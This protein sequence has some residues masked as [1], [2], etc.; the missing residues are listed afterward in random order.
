MDHDVLRGG[1]FCLYTYGE[2]LGW[3][4]L[5]RFQSGLTKEGTGRDRHYQNREFAPHNRNCIFAKAHW[6]AS[7]WEYGQTT[8]DRRRK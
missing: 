1:D 2:C 8:R 7:R 4:D 5:V 6:G 3:K